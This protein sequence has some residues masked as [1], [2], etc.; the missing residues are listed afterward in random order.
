MED[1]RRQISAG[2]EERWAPKIKE[3]EDRCVQSEEARQVAERQLAEVRQL[4]RDAC[5][6]VEEL[7]EAS[8]D[9][10]ASV[11]KAI[12]RI[13]SKERDLEAV[14]LEMQEELE[15]VKVIP[16]LSSSF[17]LLMLNF[18]PSATLTFCMSSW[19]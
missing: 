11:K 1:L 16:C 6:R 13:Q 12:N 18:S 4:H 5:R 8:E 7:Q 15:V 14:Q 2:D 3:L 9:K 19:N 10:E 17:S